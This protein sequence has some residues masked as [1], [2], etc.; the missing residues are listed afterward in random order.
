[1]LTLLRS[2]LKNKQ[3]FDLRLIAVQF[4]ADRPDVG[5]TSFCLLLFVLKQ[6]TE[7]IVLL[8]LL[9]EISLLNIILKV[10]ILINFPC[11]VV[12]FFPPSPPE[13]K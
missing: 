8:V 5:F 12:D 9:V 10:T 7:H 13:D 4:I 6:F 11:G 3:A 1:M 2:S